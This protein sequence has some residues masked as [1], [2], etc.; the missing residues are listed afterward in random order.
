M[1][2]EK[3]QEGIKTYFPVKPTNE[4]NKVIKDISEFICTINTNKI[5]LILIGK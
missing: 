4:Q 2:T 1:N 3:L 5:G